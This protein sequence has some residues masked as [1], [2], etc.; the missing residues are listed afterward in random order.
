L[1]EKVWK[2]LLQAGG[3]LEE[4]GVHSSRTLLEQA[5]VE[6][7]HFSVILLCRLGAGLNR[8]KPYFTIYVLA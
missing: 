5:L 2:L 6:N 4:K 8:Q 3:N 1:A 7:K